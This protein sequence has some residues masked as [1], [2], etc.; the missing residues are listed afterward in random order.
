MES[1]EGSL[2]SIGIA[3]VIGAATGCGSDG[4]INLPG[5]AEP[6]S[7]PSLLYAMGLEGDAF[8]FGA[9]VAARFLDESRIVV[10]DMLP[11]SVLIVHV[12]DGMVERVMTAGDGPGDAR[13]PETVGLS[14]S[15]DE[16]WVS[17]RVLSR[18]T[19]AS[20]E[21]PREFRTLGFMDFLFDPPF[22]A[23]GPLAMLADG[24]MLVAASG[25]EVPHLFPDTAVT[26]PLLVADSLGKVVDTLGVSP[27]H[28]ALSFMLPRPEG[29][30]LQIRSFLPSSP[31]LSVDPLGRYVG[32]LDRW[33][34]LGSGGGRI[35]IYDVECGCEARTM[36]APGTA[37]PVTDSVVGA[38]VG[39]MVEGSE[40]AAAW[41]GGAS[42][43]IDALVARLPRPPT[44]SPVADFVLDRQGRQWV[45]LRRD[46]ASDPT[47]LDWMMAD[48]DGQ[49]WSA[50]AFPEPVS[51]VLDAL[52]PLVLVL[53]LG[54][55]GEPSL[56]VYSLPDS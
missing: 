9:P 44:L 56:A 51:R 13:M 30:F 6:G 52:G 33:N 40:T 23:A 48:P 41:P 34:A 3:L 36:V 27:P 12:S 47:G 8:A 18:V 38:V 5:G 39:A 42:A 45:G 10:A 19:L 4:D 37:I 17:D 46:S 25:I 35:T 28:H 20:I 15:D 7:V 2:A 16:F 43:F 22:R 21:A 53:R 14:P 24:S 26:Y 31:L 32:V 54:T 11:P 49:E 55:L 29:G 50:V 1:F